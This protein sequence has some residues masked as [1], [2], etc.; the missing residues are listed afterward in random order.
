MTTLI[1]FGA[2]YLY[3]VGL[4]IFVAYLFHLPKEKIKIAFV[5]SLIDL[6]AV[7]FISFIAGH[8][9]NN[10]RPFVSDHITPLILS[11]GR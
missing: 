9:Y 4:T 11:C 10:P 1:I 6:P 7:Y 3:L 8:F 5:F 2:K